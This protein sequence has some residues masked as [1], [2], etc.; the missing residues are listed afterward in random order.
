MALVRFD[1]FR[2]L[3][4]LQGD[5]N[6]V[7]RRLGGGDMTTQRESWMPSIDVIE[8]AGGIELKVEVAGMKP[9]DI[10][11]EIDD[12][13]LTVSGERRFEEQ[14]QEDKYYRIERRYGSFS[15]S[16][17]LPQGV[18]ADNIDATYE[19]GVLSVTVPKVEQAKP[20]KISVSTGAGGPTTVEAT[21]TE[22]Q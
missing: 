16:I 8:R 5:M 7:F 20:K 13:V 19:N 1:P 11:I 18:D 10:N 9:E 14:V 17:A 22:Q 3:T 12:N 15:R 6:R 2:E 21:A 4:A